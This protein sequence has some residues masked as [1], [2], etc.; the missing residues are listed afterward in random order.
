MLRF[1]RVAWLAVLVPPLFLL[2]PCAIGCGGSV[3]STPGDGGS[4]RSADAARP[5]SDATVKSPTPDSG[6]TRVVD[7]AGPPAEAQAPEAASPPCTTVA[8]SCLYTLASGQDSPSS[9]AV[10]QGTLYWTDEHAG[11]VMKVPTAGGTPVTVVAKAQQG[12]S[13]GPGNALPT[14]VGPL[15]VYAPTIYWWAVSD[16]LTVAHSCP[17]GG[18]CDESP[19]AWWP[20]TASLSGG[21]PASLGLIMSGGPAPS[22]MS[23]VAANSDG[24]FFA[25]PGTWVIGQDT[26]EQGSGSPFGL[27]CD[28]HTI[29]WTDRSAGTVTSASTAAGGVGTNTTLATGQADPSLLALDA[30]S[31][32]WTNAGD[33]TVMKMP[34]AGGATVTVAQGQTSPYGIAV[35]SSGVYWT[36]QAGTVMKAPQDAGAPVTLASGQPT[37]YAVALDDASVYFTTYVANGSVMKLTEGCSCP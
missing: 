9:L 16:T 4:T 10:T 6:S 19:G 12:I 1:S 11:T 26:A 13:A 37:P 17:S 31:L 15:F 5:T 27:A 29:F 2:L 30:D 28:T 20:M 25:S 24:A 33:G 8:D 3:R 22:P 35:S 14:R 21:S 7:A 23:G 18:P 32:Y 34:K 36:D